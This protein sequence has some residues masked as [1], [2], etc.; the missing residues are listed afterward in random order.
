MDI[1]SVNLES[2]Q[3]QNITAMIYTIIES[4]KPGESVA[5]HMKEDPLKMLDKLNR[6]E[7]PEF[8]FSAD[9]KGEDSWKILIKKKMKIDSNS[10][11]CCGMC[12]H[13]K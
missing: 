3:G 4:L 9:R 10:V 2:F 1:T 6:A 8:D 11:G 7:L 12:G 13:E 5:L